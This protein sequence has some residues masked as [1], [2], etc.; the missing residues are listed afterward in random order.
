MRALRCKRIVQR[1][2]NQNL[3]DRRLCDPVGL[4]V[5]IGAIHVVERGRHDDAGGMVRARL[6]QAGK[7]RQLRQRDVHA[8]SGRPA[9]P[10]P[11]AGDEFRWQRTLLD[12]VEIEQL[13]IQV[14]DHAPRRHLASVAQRDA[15]RLPGFDIDAGHRR[16][17]FDLHA[18][19]FRLRRHRLSDGAHAANRVAPGTFLAVHLAEAV[20]QEHISGARVVRA[21]EIP[22]DS[23]EPKCRAHPLAFEPPVEELGGAL[24][25]KVQQVAASLHVEL[26]GEAPDLERAGEIEEAPADVR[27]AFE[28]KV[29]QHIRHPLQHGPVRGQ[30]LGVAARESCE[31]RLRCFE[32]A[33]DFKVGA[34]VQRQEVGIRPLHD[35]Q[36]VVRQVQIADHLRVE[37]AHRVG[38]DRVA[39]A[40]ME[41]LGHRRA[42]HHAA[43]LEHLH[44]EAAPGEI[45]GT[46][47]A[48]VAC[49]DDHGV[50]AGC[51]G[52]SGCGSV[53]GYTESI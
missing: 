10:A 35:P 23:V 20:V 31:F 13:R 11:H 15:D 45:A 2:G 26:L 48:V 46:G 52:H 53:R 42:A 27:R 49:A 22:H 51:R 25:E 7:A 24:G 17:A 18:E 28:H 50:V 43:A 44:L 32:P 29:A 16:I 33:A 4:C 34:P 5:E 19:P 14:A 40:R 36:A 6:R 41:F 47:K 9:L 3:D 30:A 38:S 39:E 37:Q 8:K 12:E 1:A 21:R